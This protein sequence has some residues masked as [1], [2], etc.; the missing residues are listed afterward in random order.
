M[1]LPDSFEKL[2]D[3]AQEQKLYKRIIQ[4]LNKD[5]STAAV[6]LYF[7]ESLTPEA[8]KQELQQLVKHLMQF[9]F[10]RYLNL[11]Y[12]VDVSELR[13]RRLPSKEINQLSGAVTFLILQREWQ[14]V[15]IRQALS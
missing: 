1:S 4:Q 13:I 11:L 7:Q 9:E 15:S 5:L 6:E 3:S 14:K 12:I 10:D 2:V 8:L